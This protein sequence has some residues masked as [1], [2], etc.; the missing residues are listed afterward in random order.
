[1]S[2]PTNLVAADTAVSRDVD[3]PL[4]SWLNEPLLHFALFGLLLFAIDHYLVT[5]ADD[6]RTI[7]VSTDVDQ[8][9]REAFKAARGR[10]P[11]ADEM[12]SLR[13]TWLDNEVLYREGLEMQLDKGDSAIR[14]RV[15][16]KALSVVDAATKL[17]SADERTLR[18]WFEDHRDKYDEPPRFDFLEETPAGERS[19]SAVRALV[20]VINSG[21]QGDTKA[22]LQIFKGRPRSNLV[23]SYG[24]D[25]AKAL[26][27]APAGEWRAYATSEGWRAIRLESITPAKPT[28]FEAAQVSVRQDWADAELAAQRTA[29]VRG[30]LRK[31]KIKIAAESL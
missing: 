14:D 6:P 23:L 18:K 20:A 22:G 2:K 15:I 12:Q 24:A 9:A 3:R 5:R 25:F 30:L 29:A 7:V 31:Y 16:F 4:S 19:E 28:T 1:M 26:E 13:Q 21:T 11:K 17:P 10:D 8:E 27:D